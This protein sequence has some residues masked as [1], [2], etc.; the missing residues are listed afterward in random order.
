VPTELRRG[1]HGEPV[2]DLQQRL[3]ALGREVGSDEPGDFGAGTEAAVRA[4]QHDRGLRV[5][6]VV[7]RETWSAIVEAGLSLGD[8]LLYLHQP[9]LRGDDV[10]DLQRR[11]N[12]LGFD[13]GREDGIYGRDTE[14]ALVEFQ[15]SCAL[16]PDGI[17]GSLVID[18]L[19]R[20]GALA[21]GSMAAVREREHLR[22]PQPGLAEHRVLVAAT[23]GLV[24]LGDHVVRSL[25]EMGAW[26]ILDGSGDEES[27]LAQ[28]ANR[29]G[30][31]L[32]LALRPGARPGWRCEY[33]ASGR[34]RSEAGRAIATAIHAE[35][36]PLIRSP[37]ELSGK[38]Y[39]LLRETRMAAVVCEVVPADDID[40][41]RKLVTASAAVGRAIARGVRLGIE[42]P[43]IEDS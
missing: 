17:C 9:M 42:Q 14:G 26:A 33:F 21:D 4:F 32:L 25:T 6:S 36:T 43:R 1:S 28:G 30:A 12:S 2:R 23:P 13:A 37:D 20:V 22:G 19:R 31:D 39:A 8:R 35:L 16:T 11:L 15:R 41:M 18:T 5:D 40:A 3:G 10:A 34:F 24:V 38:A 7:G 27:W 29:F